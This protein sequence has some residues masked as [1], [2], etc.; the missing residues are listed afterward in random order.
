MGNGK[1][2]K[3]GSGDVIYKKALSNAAAFN[4]GEFAQ[5]VAEDSG[6]MVKVSKLNDFAKLLKE[7]NCKKPVVHMGVYKGDLVITVQ[8]A[9]GFMDTEVI[10]KGYE[11]MKT[12]RAKV[13]VVNAQRG[14][15][16]ID[17]SSDRMAKAKGTKTQD[18]KDAELKEVTGDII[19]LAHGGNRGSKPGKVYASSFG[20]KKPKDIVTYLVKTKKLPTSY[21]GTIYLDGCYTAAGASKGTKQSDLNNFCGTVYAGLKKAGYEY[22][23]VK[24]NLGL[25]VTK[26]DGTEDVVDAQMEALI[27]KKVKPIEKKRSEAKKNYEQ[28]NKKVVALLLERKKYEAVLSKAPNDAVRVKV[29][30]KIDD[31]KSKESKL[32]PYAEKADKEYTAADKAKRELIATLKKKGISDDKITD[33]V[34][35]FGPEKLG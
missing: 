33:L 6:A 2:T 15:D 30:S 23:Q 25:A 8:S 31:L 20:D 26:D 21:S 34:G 5:K 22:L 4:V 17:T 12:D 13:A 19:I 28:I 35:T 11:K 14:D 18:A 3:F 16:T 10:V 29:Q 32:K 24:G 9:D 27:K 1:L 7:Q